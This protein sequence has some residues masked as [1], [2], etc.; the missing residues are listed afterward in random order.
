MTFIPIEEAHAVCAK[1]VAVTDSPAELAVELDRVYSWL[2]EVVPPRF[3]EL[4]HHEQRRL[5]VAPA[6]SQLTGR[7]TALAQVDGLPTALKIALSSDNSTAALKAAEII[8]VTM[9]ATRH[10]PSS[11]RNV[12]LLPQRLLINGPLVGAMID[13]LA[14]TESAD[15]YRVL[16]IALAATLRQSSIGFDMAL[17]RG[18]I[19]VVISHMKR[20]R[21]SCTQAQPHLTM[22]LATIV[23][24]SDY[25]PQPTKSD[26]SILSPVS[27]QSEAEY[28]QKPRREFDDT[29]DKYTS[30]RINLAPVLDEIGQHFKECVLIDDNEHDAAGVVRAGLVGL[31]GLVRNRMIISILNDELV[32]TRIAHHLSHGLHEAIQLVKAISECHSATA[33]DFIKSILPNADTLVSD[34]VNCLSA[35]SSGNCGDDGEDGDDGKLA[36]VIDSLDLIACLYSL[37]V[38]MRSAVAGSTLPQQLLQLLNDPGI[39]VDVVLRMAAIRTLVSIASSTLLPLPEEL[40]VSIVATLVNVVRQFEHVQ[41]AREAVDG[42]CGLKFTSIELYRICTQHPVHAVLLERFDQL[43]QEPAEH[44]ALQP[45]LTVLS[46]LI[47]RDATASVAIAAHPGL[48]TRI[49]QLSA[50]TDT[51][52]LAICALYLWQQLLDKELTVL[53]H[54][55]M[56][57]LITSAT[58]LALRNDVTSHEAGTALEALYFVYYDLVLADRHRIVSLCCSLFRGKCHSALLYPTGALLDA[59][60]C[61]LTIDDKMYVATIADVTSSLDMAASH[62][63]NKRAVAILDHCPA[64]PNNYPAL[65]QPADSSV[66]ATTDAIRALHALITASRSEPD[67]ALDCMF[68]HG[69][70]SIAMWYRQSTAD[71]ILSLYRELQFDE[72]LVDIALNTGSSLEVRYNIIY[73]FMRCIKPFSVPG[74]SNSTSQQMQQLEYMTIQLVGQLGSMDPILVQLTST[75]VTRIANYMTDAGKHQLISASTQICHRFQEGDHHIPLFTLLHAAT[76]V[77]VCGD[78]NS[79]GLSFALRIV[80]DLACDTFGSIGVHPRHTELLMNIPQLSW[81]FHQLQTGNQIPR[82][83]DLVNVLLATVCY[84]GLPDNMVTLAAN[85]LK[86]LLSDCDPTHLTKVSVR[87]QTELQTELQHLLIPCSNNN[88]SSNSSSSN[89]SNSDVY[90][91]AVAEL[92][93]TLLGRPSNLFNRLSNSCMYEYVVQRVDSSIDDETFPAVYG[94]FSDSISR[95]QLR[96]E[97]HGLMRVLTR[98]L[99]S[100]SIS[101]CITALSA[102]HNFALNNR[103]RNNLDV[104]DVNIL[105]ALHDLL[106]NSSVPFLIKSKV[107]DYIDM[108]EKRISYSNVFGGAAGLRIRT[109]KERMIGMLPT[110]LQAVSESPSVHLATMFINIIASI[111]QLD[112]I[113]F[114]SSQYVN[115]ASQQM[116]KF[117]IQPFASPSFSTSALDQCG[118]WAMKLRVL[119]C[120]RHVQKLNN[121]QPFRGLAS[122][123]SPTFI[124]CLLGIARDSHCPAALRGLSLTIINTIQQS[125]SGF[126][127]VR[128]APHLSESALYDFSITIDELSSLRY[129]GSDIPFSLKVCT[130]DLVFDTIRRKFNARRSDNTPEISISE[131]ITKYSSLL[132]AVARAMRRMP[133]DHALPKTATR[134]LSLVNPLHLSTLFEGGYI[135]RQGREVAADKIRLSSELSNAMY[136]VISAILEGDNQT[137]QSK[138]AVQTIQF[139][140]SLCPRPQNPHQPPQLPPPLPLI[141]GG[142]GLFNQQQQQQQQQQQRRTPTI[143]PDFCLG[144]VRCHSSLLCQLLRNSELTYRESLTSVIVKMAN[145]TSSS[146]EFFE[147]FVETNILRAVFD[148]ASSGLNG[149]GRS[150]IQP[151]CRFMSLPQ[152]MPTSSHHQHSESQIR[153]WN[154]FMA[155]FASILIKEFEHA[156]ESFKR[157][158]LKQ[159]AAT[160]YTGSTATN[161][162]RVSAA[163]GIFGFSTFQSHLHMSIVPLLNTISPQRANQN[164]A[165]L[166]GDMFND[167]EPVT[168]PELLEH[169]CRSDGGRGGERI[170]NALEMCLAYSPNDIKYIKAV[171]SF[172]DQQFG[173]DDCDLSLD[174]LQPI[175]PD[176]NPY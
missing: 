13:A 54:P 98:A 143:H 170:R 45:V 128:N 162:T 135:D 81:I 169:V 161:R 80:S 15:V 16:C 71:V 28:S 25:N 113:S 117:V 103:T 27:Q 119:R 61:T 155:E 121:H 88:N 2:S 159:R 52:H 63:V 18:L 79:E 99:R 17:S 115:T 116:L 107:V 122:I 104:V 94:L 30:V 82:H 39:R 48:V 65:Y 123:F 1:L 141:F 78:C 152:F 167:N 7:A 34:V 132:S 140:S 49:C 69:A 134:I 174:S 173:G 142:G 147:L 93:T 109:I 44:D 12:S 153:A 160:R 31:T 105:D 168:H 50:G 137:D 75:L 166:F 148:G 111:S 130:R 47:D 129:S 131:V 33:K 70:T 172:I 112:G 22:L 175:S 9:N 171:R 97:K 156:A 35:L 145:A 87:I 11:E 120:I 84:Q 37:D 36:N 96:L 74:Y 124:D 59:V 62:E 146:D 114:T 100:S 85:C 149:L 165:G 60:L 144:F 164:N 58:Q 55:E 4:S 3:L 6:V 10:T 24:M 43:S 138:T 151:L 86:A 42:F 106:A 29:P 133:S 139:L 14:S 89:N 5:A 64:P 66:F 90:Y 101:T 95:F 176:I 41:L 68:L 110:L 20:L 57:S 77:V 67:C 136:A 19:N 125:S 23:F 127:M 118:S 53:P 51:P 46:T 56:E 8:A 163:A 157:L 83:D 150:V 32:L 73:G 158:I 126:A 92:L 76:F 38:N 40:T 91:R 72:I 21:S 102:L 26:H 154:E 108:I